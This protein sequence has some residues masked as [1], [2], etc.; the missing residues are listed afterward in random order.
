MGLRE[1]L[2]QR[3][4]DLEIPFDQAGFDPYGMSREHLRKVGLACG[5][6]A[7]SYFRVEAFGVENVP[8][9]GRAMLVANHSGGYGLD[10]A[11]LAA[12]VFWEKTPPRLAQGMA[13][14][15]LGK[16]PVAS[17]WTHRIGQLTGLP[18]HARRLL[19]DERLLMVFP[20]GVRGTAKLFGQRHSLV[21]FGTGFMRLALSTGTPIV[22]V[23][24]VGCGEAVPTVANLRWL[25]KLVGLPYIPITY[26]GIAAPLP[27]KMRFH[28]GKPFYFEGGNQ[29]EDRAVEDYVEQVRGEIRNLIAQGAREYNWR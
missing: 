22:P 21:R 2:N 27:V 1:E 19:E 20:E 17:A 24:I 8:D 7:R 10:A 12:S 29:L 11:M 28:F 3:I 18:Q 15:F 14:K 23:G 16:L 5:V 4:S 9:T 26:Y 13:D 6:A 25:G